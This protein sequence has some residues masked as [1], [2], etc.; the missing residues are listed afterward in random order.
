MVKAS[1]RAFDFSLLLVTLLLGASGIVLIYSAYEVSQ[2][3]SGRAWFEN[4]VIRQGMFGAIGLVFYALAMLFDY[5]WWGALQRWL[6]LV[7]LGLLGVTMALG[8]TEFGAQSWLGVQVFGIQPSEFCKVLMILVLAQVLGKQEQD[9]DSPWPLVLSGLLIIPP[10]ALI[11]LQPDFGTA[12]ILVATWAGMVFLSGVRWRFL[13]LLG[14]A[15]VVAAPVAW[16]QLK[17]Y[18][19]QRIL[20]FFYP[21]QDPSGASYNITQALISIGSGG[22]WGKGY[23][24]GTQTQLR[25]LRV[26]H[27]DFIFSVLAEEFGFI[28]AMLLLVLFAFLILRLMRIAHRAADAQGRLIV[29]GVATMI[30]VQTV[31]NLGMN[32]QVLPVT[33]LPLPLI[34]YGGSSLMATLLALGLAQSVAVRQRVEEITLF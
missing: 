16:T 10:V 31:I 3:A 13:L 29:S 21:N 34:S 5:R 19:R 15:G 22:W 20:T 17:G 23:L 25:F 11:Y 14:G 12:L 7:V 8:R 27:T 33:G 32:A 4:T 1:W 30:L 18:M 28:G 9:P 2:S 24:Q 6:Y 26:R